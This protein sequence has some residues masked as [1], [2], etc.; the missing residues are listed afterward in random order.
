MN[1]QTFAQKHDSGNK[2]QIYKKYIL[3]ELTK[4]ASKEIAEEIL[5]FYEEC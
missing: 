2:N 3:Q 4:K 1:I 5:K